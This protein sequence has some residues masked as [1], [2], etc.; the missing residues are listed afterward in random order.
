MPHYCILL[1]VVSGDTRN[2]RLST[3]SDVANYAI[4]RD[5][6]GDGVIDRYI[7]GVGGTAA[8]AGVNRDGVPIEVVVEAMIGYNQDVPSN[9][10]NALDTTPRR[11]GLVRQIAFNPPKIRSDID[12]YL[13][14]L[15]G[16]DGCDKVLTMIPGD[17]IGA[18]DNAALLAKFAPLS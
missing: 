3:C 6:D 15:A 18:V 11:A 5:D 9:I 12:T 1:S 13:R 7:L 17:I 14:R 10:L 2:N 16:Q 8:T 4:G